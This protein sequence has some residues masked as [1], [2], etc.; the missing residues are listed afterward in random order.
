M[1]PEQN[2]GN[3][4]FEEIVHDD[5][6]VELRLNRPRVLNVLNTTMY[7]QIGEKIKQY[8]NRSDIRI[9]L[10][11]ANGKTFCAGMDIVEV[12][13]AEDVKAVISSTR[14]FM[15]ALMECPHIIIAA[16]FG[17]VVGIGVTMLLHCDLVI[18]HPETCF[19]TPFPSVGIVPEFASS[20]L[21]PRMLGA[22]L[23]TRLLLR[24]E[25]VTAKEM[26]RA[27]ALQIVNSDV[28]KGAL[29]HARTWS[30]SMSDDE[31]VMVEASK[32]L[33]RHPIREKSR[34]MMQLEFDAIFRAHDSGVLPDLIKRKVRQ[35]SARRAM[36]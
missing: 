4:L 24:C 22:S 27:G 30:Q 26:E 33:I 15:D 10:L 11:T 23:A 8:S 18:A 3:R 19:E 2:S 17:H 35:L 13:K 32:E 20:Y 7:Q 6:I 31:W 16:V 1:G 21:I 34:Q 36:L 29:G 12:S 28:Q 14:I 5:G 25:C 9:I